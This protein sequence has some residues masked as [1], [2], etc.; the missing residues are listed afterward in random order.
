[1]CDINHLDPANLVHYLE[2]YGVDPLPAEN[3][4]PKNCLRRGMLKEKVGCTQ[5]DNY[6]CH[7][8]Q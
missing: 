7:I 4:V 8:C 1:M 5:A 6:A 2:G 3:A